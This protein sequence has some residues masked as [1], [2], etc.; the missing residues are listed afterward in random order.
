MK[1]PVKVTEAIFPMPV[2]LIATYNE[3]EAPWGVSLLSRHVSPDGDGQDDRL[4]VVLHFD[5]PVQVRLTVCSLYGNTLAVLL[6]GAF[7]G[8]QCYWWEV[9]DTN[10]RAI[11]PG[12]CLLVC[13]ILGDG[14]LRQFKKIPFV[15]A[16]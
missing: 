15:V 9:T 14:G 3:D 10:G 1:Q 2:L 5:Q 16:D 12:I 4:G 13:E 7:C 8:R 6:D 11:A